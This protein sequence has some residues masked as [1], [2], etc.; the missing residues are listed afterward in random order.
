MYPTI[1]N[2]LKPLYYQLRMAGLLTFTLDS[3]GNVKSIH[4]YLLMICGLNSTFTTLCTY[5]YANNLFKI[6]KSLTMYLLSITSTIGG[7]N[8][9]IMDLFRC[10]NRNT[11]TNIWKD[12]FRTDNIYLDENITLNYNVIQYFWN[13]IIWIQLILRILA[14][15]LLIS[16]WEMTTNFDI[17]DIVLVISYIRNS[18]ATIEFITLR[19]KTACYFYNFF[20]LLQKKSFTVRQLKQNKSLLSLYFNLCQLSRNIDRIVS[21]QIIFKLLETFFM[22][23]ILLYNVISQGI[24]ARI[25]HLTLSAIY[26]WYSLLDCCLTLIY[27]IVPVHLSIK[28]V[29]TCML[30]LIQSLF[31][32]IFK[33]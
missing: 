2:G 21:P 31:S 13:L 15:N 1:S 7:I 11:V 6:D 32:N 12:V 33:T 30:L 14:I 10:F 4:S 17:S 5:W 9:V 20:A 28:N 19:I 24:Y 22:L 29:S 27:V 18:V 25:D 16:K 8:M 23:N 26:V 3:S